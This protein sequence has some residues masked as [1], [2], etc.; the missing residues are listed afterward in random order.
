MI[1]MI[2]FTSP[3]QLQCD[4]EKLM[5]EGGEERGDR[6][7]YRVRDFTL[8]DESHALV[9]LEEDFSIVRIRFTY[10]GENVKLLEDQHRDGYLSYQEIQLIS[11]LGTIVLKGYEY[12]IEE[13]KYCIDESGVR[14]M[15]IILN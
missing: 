7:R 11:D 8:T 4:L 2:K 5:C 13:L 12:A 10:N 14:Y 15:E 6:G 3:D 9:C 1:K